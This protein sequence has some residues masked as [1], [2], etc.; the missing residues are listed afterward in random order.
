MPR[1]LYEGLD[2]LE[3]LQF[4]VGEVAVYWWFLLHHTLIFVQRR[5][6]LQQ[7][8]AFSFETPF[9]FNKHFLIHCDHDD[10]QVL[11]GATY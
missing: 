4:C 2:Y 8:V 7:K 10:L 6:I 1:I 5:P 11:H 3:A 9:S